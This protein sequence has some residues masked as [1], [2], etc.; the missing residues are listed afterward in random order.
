VSGRRDG[1]DWVRFL[2]TNG[3]FDSA[4]ADIGFVS[5]T[6]LFRGRSFLV[7]CCARTVPFDRAAVGV[8]ARGDVT[9]SPIP[10]IHRTSC[11]VKKNRGIGVEGSRNRGREAEIPSRTARDDRPTPPLRA[12]D[13]AACVPAGLGRRAGAHVFVCGQDVA[14]E[15]VAIAVD[16]FPFVATGEARTSELMSE[17][18]AYCTRL[19][20]VASPIR[21]T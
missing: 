15:H 3:V 6:F 21:L 17:R 12:A 5:S 16:V 7:L 2:N 9:R 14:A 20:F 8:A 4:R 18:S 1:F 19:S 10:N 13:R 11:R